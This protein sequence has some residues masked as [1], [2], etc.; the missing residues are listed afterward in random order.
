[1]N[2]GTMI[3]GLLG[4]IMK[5]HSKSVF[6]PEKVTGLQKCIYFMF[7]CV[8]RPLRQPELQY[9]N[10]QRRFMFPFRITTIDGYFRGFK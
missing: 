5:F 2:Q 6:L 9:P 10:Q 8:R 7:E 1:M 3:M 4:I